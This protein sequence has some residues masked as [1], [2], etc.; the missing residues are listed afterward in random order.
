MSHPAHARPP[1]DDENTPLPSL[2]AEANEARLALGPARPP[3]D[4]EDDDMDLPPLDADDDGDENGTK[5]ELDDALPEL[6]DDGGDPLD[7]ANAQ[8]LDIG[9]QIEDES[10]RSA[11]DEA[12]G[13]DVGALDEDISD[14]EEESALDDGHEATGLDDDDASSDLD[15]D[16]TSDDGGAEGTGENAENDVDE[17]ALPE[18]DESEHDE[19]DDRL[20]DLLLEEATRGKIPPW[21]PTRFFVLEGAGAPV[22]CAAVTVAFGRVLAAGDEVLLVDEGAHAARRT[23]IETP[24]TA[25]AATEDMTVIAT[26]RGNL[27]ASRDGC[28]SATAVSGFRTGKGPVGLAATAGRIWILHDEALWSMTGQGS[29]PVLARE[30]GVRAIAASGGSLVVLT[31]RPEGA[32]I[33]RLRGD[34]EAWQATPLPSE[35]AAQIAPEPRPTLAAALGGKRV[36]IVSSKGL[37]LSNDGG[38]SFESTDLQD[39]VAACF[40]GDDEDAPLLALVAT[41]EATTSYLV[42]ITEDAEPSRVAELRGPDGASFTAAS[43]AWDASREL[44]W[45]GG[46]QGLFALG[47]ARQH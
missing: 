9:V 28:A 38:R 16:T 37:S 45:I 47:L 24:C 19:A 46:R 1:G 18:L 26:A 34:D 44:V 13:V 3:Q 40:A 23:G 11:S 39:V 5:E 35:I 15:E 2:A 4:D 10:D 32:A 36:A 21:A 14:L 27:F 31:A 33:E 8:D 12:E 42:R 29:A 6:R 7:D 20:A 22:P 30:N 17:S 43:I 25:I 41:P